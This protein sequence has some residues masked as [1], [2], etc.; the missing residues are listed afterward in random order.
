MN[1]IRSHGFEMVV[2][3]DS[4]IKELTDLK[5]KKLGVGAL[6]WGNIPMSRAMLADAGIEWSKDI[7][8]FPVGIGPA[9]WRRLETGEIDALNLFVSQH[10]TMELAGIDIRRLPLPENFRT[11]FSNGWVANDTFMKERP[12]VIESFGRAL[13]K[14]WIACKEQPEACVKAHWKDYP[15]EAPSADKEAE[16]LAADAKRAL[17]DGKMIDDFAAGEE[18]VYGGYSQDTWARLI[19]VMYSQGQIE[20][21]DIDV[22]KFFDNRFVGAFNDYDAEAVKSAARKRVQ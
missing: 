21:K 19:D 2:G 9:A 3:K 15:A 14:S 16:Q 7:E 5:G 18:Q 11:I 10:G 4:P 1:W 20:T 22:S 13:V 8:I 12:E 6:T 17:F